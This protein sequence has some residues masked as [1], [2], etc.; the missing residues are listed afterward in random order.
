VPT[1]TP[2][3]DDGGDL[4]RVAECPTDHLL[5]PPPLPAPLELVELVELTDR[6]R[7][8]RAADPT[9]DRSPRPSGSP[10]GPADPFPP[11]GARVLHFEM[12]EEIGRGAF[13]RVYLARQESLANRLVVV[14]VTTA[15]T[16]EPQTLARLRHTNVIPVYSVHDTAAFQ[17]ICMPYL[18]QTT[19]SRALLALPDD[20]PSHARALLKHARTTGH[21]L[22]RLSYADGCLWVI[23]QLAAGLEHA[24]GTGTLHR[25]LKP[26]NVL[27]TDDGT[28]MILDF[29]VASPAGAPAHPGS[30]VGGTFPY[31]A[32]EHLRAFAGEAAVVDARSDLFSLGVMLYQMLTFELP[33]P[34]VTLPSRAETV[35]RQIEL[36]HA[37]A[38][39]VRALNPAVSHSV[40]AVVAKLLDPDPA[41]RYQTAADLREDVTRH[42]ADEPLRHASCPSGR[43]RL[44]KWRRRHPRLATAAAVAAVALTLFVLPATVIAVRQ[45]QLNE[46]MKA[47]QRAEAVVK[48]EDAVAELRVAA[49]ELGSRSDPAARARGLDAARAVVERYAAADPDWEARPDVAPLDDARRGALRAALAEVLVLMTRAEAQAGGFSPEAV[50]AGLRW[51]AAAARLFAPDARPAVLGRLAE[52]LPARRDRRPVPPL[53]VSGRD[54]DLQFDGIDLAAADR[55]REALPLLARFCDRHPDHF[56][57]WFARGVCHDALGQHADAATCFSVCLAVVPDFPRAVANRGAARLHQQRWPEA[58]ADFTRALELKPNWTV[59]L[60]NRGLAYEGQ[61]RWPEAEADYTAALAA[62]DAPTRLYFL[63]AQV[64]R[65]RGDAAGADADFAAGLRLEPA[66]P[67]SWVSRGTKRMAREPKAALADFDAALK[68][69]PNM[70]EALLNKAVVLADHLNRAA[71]AVPVLDRLLEL[72]PD[73]TEARAGRGVYNAR[74][75]RSAAARADAAAVLKAEPIAYRQYQMAGLYAQLAKHNPNGPDRREAMKLLAQSLRGF[76]DAALLATDADLDPIRGDAEFQRL[77]AAVAQ[78]VAR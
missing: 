38:E 67:I 30:T 50:E 18:G 74:L 66:D 26:A 9:P 57:A 75:G 36:R 49:V 44:A 32:P 10:P 35:R 45:S 53:A 59:A 47:V 56:Q 55:H 62:A 39:P 8:P 58:E 20:P 27:L 60:V 46:R 54:V 76:D 3:P 7:P 14:K 52:E 63:R 11:V 31:M 2:L 68:L 77:V 24:H 48:A 33:F 28:P 21:I 1:P 69:S 29:N 72:Y 71:D 43:E 65:A 78:V 70:R 19:L 37:A 51:N 12:V 61:R 17:V 25:D 15:R 40:A 5:T 73:H 4:R 23:G 22:E 42:L 16:D 34:V 41:R 64:R 13:A 6:V